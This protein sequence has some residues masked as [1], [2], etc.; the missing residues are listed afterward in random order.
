MP[1]KKKPRP[2]QADRKQVVSWINDR[3]LEAD[4]QV[5]PPRGSLRLRRLTRLQYENAVH[6][7]LAIDVALKERLPEDKRAF[8]FDNV[9][10][11][12]NLSPAQLE[13]YLEAADAA[14]DA[15]IVK[16][17]RPE[18]WKRRFESLG[19]DAETRKAILDLE[20]AVV[21]FGRALWPA[22][23]PARQGDGCYRFRLSAC[24]YQSKGEPR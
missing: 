23:V 20:D 6:D 2:P 17:A 11:A 9:G 16:K 18:T 15:A 12:L 4:R 21:L 3:L 19:G 13:V 7:L 8:G 5:Q 1:P 24:A 14:L 10:E 22:P